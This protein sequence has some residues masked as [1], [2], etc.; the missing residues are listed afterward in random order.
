MKDKILHILQKNRKCDLNAKDIDRLLVY[1]PKSKRLAISKDILLFS[2]YSRL[3]F[4]RIRK[5]VYSSLIIDDEGGV[6]IKLRKKDKGIYEVFKISP[7]AS[8]I[9]DK[10][11]PPFKPDNNS[12]LFLL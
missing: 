2:Y 1:K 6:W 9:L 3:R 4:S 5:L 7:E 11:I 12:K 8:K 10:Y